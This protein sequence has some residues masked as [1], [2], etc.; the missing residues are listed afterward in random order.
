MEAELDSASSA[1]MLLGVLLMQS[2]KNDAVAEA[3]EGLFELDLEREW[4]YGSR[5]ELRGIA[6][7]LEDARACPLHDLDREFHRLFVGPQHLE[8][9]PW[10]SVYLDAEAVVFGDSCKDLVRWM[11]RHGIALHEGAS[12]EPADQI[13][14]MFVLL[15]WICRN[16]PA[17]LDEYLQCHLLTWAPT[18]LERLQGAASGPFY[19]AVAKLAALTL[20]GIDAQRNAA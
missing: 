15:S 4:P 14:R 10:G 13:G 12:R 9:P 18:Y 7:L 2:P 6:A 1:A 20:E 11:R 16:D 3:I 17:L 5:E 8:A 19:R